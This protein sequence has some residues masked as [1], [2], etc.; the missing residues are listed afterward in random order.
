M[1]LHKVER[2][3]N[4]L[5]CVEPTTYAS[6]RWRERDH[7][8]PLLRDNP[9]VLDPG[10]LIVSEEFNNWEGS[11]RRIDLLGLEK[12]GNLVVIELKQEE[13]GGHMELQAVR[14]A[15]MVSAMDFEA[16]VH[17]Y[18]SF[19]TKFGK[20]TTAARLEIKTFLAVADNDE[21]VITNLPRIILVAPNFSREIATTVL[22]L[23]DQGL[24]IRCIAANL[25]RIQEDD[26]LQIDQI[27]PLPSA[28]DYQFKMREKSIKA[29]WDATAIR[30]GRSLEILIKTG[31]LTEG[32]RI[33]L[34]KSPRAGLVISDEKAKRAT[35]Q[36]GDKFIWEYDGKPYPLSKLCETIVEKFGGDVLSGSFPGPD[37]WALDGETV[38]LA[39]RAKEHEAA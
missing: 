3:P 1:P 25:Y 31:V 22:W 18:E 9:E 7:L 32:T 27:I 29:E 34:L 11:S 16:V 24:G 20:D 37:Y 15:A 17:A 13:G 4:K 36:G 28:A 19:L 21:P 10:L 8:Q 6:E 26:Y 23:N 35:F 12:E 2:D 33:N 14:Y 38:S 5:I 39:R 30:R